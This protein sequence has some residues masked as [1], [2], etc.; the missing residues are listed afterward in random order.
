MVFWHMASAF[1]IKLKSPSYSCHCMTTMQATWPGHVPQMTQAKKPVWKRRYGGS[2]P[3]LI[4]P[5]ML[6]SLL[7]FMT[8]P[9]VV[10]S[11]HNQ[12]PSSVVVACGLVYLC[13]Q[14][15]EYGTVVLVLLGGC[16]LVADGFPHMQCSPTIICVLLHDCHMRSAA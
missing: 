13:K 16:L 1:Q 7:A 12:P 3:R 2:R 5:G 6:S 14:A 15:C 9:V 10:E 11:M 4:W 8:V